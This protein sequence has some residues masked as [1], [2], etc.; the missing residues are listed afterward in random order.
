MLVQDANGNGDVREA[1]LAV[2]GADI[3]AGVLGR[4]WRA[5]VKARRSIPKV[6]QPE[7]DDTE[8]EPEAPPVPG[9][10]ARLVRPG[11]RPLVLA[12]EYLGLMRLFEGTPTTMAERVAMA[13]ARRQRA[14]AAAPE[15]E[16][17]IP[18][19][20]T[21]SPFRTSTATSATP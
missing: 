16:I 3:L 21:K 10:L 20:H 8:E 2:G 1:V 13:V 7:I 11:A 15:P 17:S 12:G 14:A 4:T 5:T 18:V 6:F 19:R 9:A